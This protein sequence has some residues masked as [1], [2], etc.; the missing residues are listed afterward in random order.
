VITEITTK[1]KK[2]RGRDGRK[3]TDYSVGFFIVQAQ[4]AYPGSAGRL[5]RACNPAR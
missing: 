1:G 3:P 2:Y 5:A 4:A